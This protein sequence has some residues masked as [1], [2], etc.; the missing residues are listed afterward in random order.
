[1]RRNI[2]IVSPRLPWPLYSGGNIG[3]YYILDYIRKY[4]DITFVTLSDWH[5]RNGK[6]MAELEKRFPEIHFMLYDWQK[7]PF[8]THDFLYKLI[9]KI[10]ERFRCPGGEKFAALLPLL[11]TTPGFIQYVNDVIKERKID[12]VQ[13]EFLSPIRLVYAL[14]D[15]V[16]KI[17]VHHELGW[18]VRAQSCGNDIYS[19]FV[20]KYLDAEEISAL[21]QYDTVISVTDVDKQKLLAAGVRA[22]VI[23]STSP[24]TDKLLPKARH[25]YDGRLTFIGGSDHPWNYTGIK[26]FVESVFPLVKAKYPETKLEVI[27]VWKDDK[28]EDIHQIDKD[29]AFKGFVED[30]TDILRNSIFVVPIN[31]GSGMRMKILEAANHSVPFVSTVVGAEGLVFKDEEDCFIKDSPKAMADAIVRLIEDDRLYQKFSA[32]VHDVFASD[33]TQEAAGKKRLTAYE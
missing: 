18:V 20:R 7:S 16:R 26:W 31:V 21:N 19:N 15:N 33:Y 17:F 14:P 1:M 23:V 8:R 30:L 25:K 9:V 11:G 13:V 6:Y 5:K 4:E 3:V 24:V 10:G 28:I 12:I 22:N 32:K 29:V 27:G 2:L